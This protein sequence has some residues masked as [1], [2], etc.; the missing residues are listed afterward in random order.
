LIPVKISPDKQDINE[1][2]RVEAKFY[3]REDCSGDANL[4]TS[5]LDLSKGDSGVVHQCAALAVS[6]VG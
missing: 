3:K 6:D 4:I 5:Y 1:E 2:V